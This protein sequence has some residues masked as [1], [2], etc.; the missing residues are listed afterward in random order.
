MCHV[1][2]RVWRVSTSCVLIPM[3]ASDKLMIGLPFNS[4]LSIYTSQHIRTLI[5]NTVVCYCFQ[6]VYA[7]EFALMQHIRT[8]ASARKQNITLPYKCVQ[9]PVSNFIL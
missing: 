1:C 3:H 5:L 8:H 7:Q 6:T 2:G 9:L 4:V